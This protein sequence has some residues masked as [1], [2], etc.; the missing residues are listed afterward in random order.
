MRDEGSGNRDQ[1]SG[2]RIAQYAAGM[3]VHVSPVTHPVSPISR[4][5]STW[6]TSLTTYRYGAWLERAMIATALAGAVVA[7]GLLP[8]YPVEWRAVLSLAVLGLAIWS[9]PVGYFVAVAVVAYP[10]WFISP[11][12]MVLL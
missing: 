12:L 6:I 7:S 4:A 8:G 10:L 3:R 2:L 5:M 1:R 9:A 11:Y